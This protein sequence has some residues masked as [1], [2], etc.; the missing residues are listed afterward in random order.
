MRSDL[1]YPGAH[2]LAEVGDTV[3]VRLRLGAGQIQGGTSLY[4]TDARFRLSCSYCQIGAGGPVE[5]AGNLS[6][7]CGVTWDADAYYGD[8]VML[9]PQ[10]GLA[11]PANGHCD[12]EFDVLIQGRGVMFQSAFME[13]FCNT[14]PPLVASSVLFGNLTTCPVCDD[15]NQC[16]GIETCDRD[17]GCLAGTP[18]FCDDHDVC[19]SDACEPA[20]PSPDD[21]CSFTSGAQGSCDDHNECTT[22]SCDASLGCVNSALPDDSA[23]DDGDSCTTADRCQSG[24]CGGVSPG[25]PEVGDNLVLLQVG[26]VTQIQW[27]GDSLPGP[28]HFYRG[29]R[30]PAEPWS[31]DEQCLGLLNTT[32]AIDA[33][34]G[35]PGALLWY[36]VSRGQGCEESVLGR[37]SQGR[38]I[39]RTST[40]P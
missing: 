25:L 35:D 11:I 22:D 12:L 33:T 24:V 23:C 30:E 6:T 40:C 4:I 29:V 7:T 36:L 32:S 39:P 2:R 1:S 3:R 9:R 21:P 13:G 38:P 14:S 34:A 28:Y 18:L 20:V 37:N 31:Y 15:G 16:N 26:G 5:Y 8:E 27:S 17:L 10:G 19:T